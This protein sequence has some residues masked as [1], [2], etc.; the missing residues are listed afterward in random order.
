VTIGPGQAFREYV[1]RRTSLLGNVAMEIKQELLRCIAKYFNN[2][3]DDEMR[4]EKQDREME[5]T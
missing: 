5:K 1:L 3:D 2:D 4:K